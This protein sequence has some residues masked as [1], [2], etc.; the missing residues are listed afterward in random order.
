MAIFACVWYSSIAFQSLIGRLKTED[1][2][3]FK[4]RPRDPFQSL[5][6]RLKTHWHGA[7]NCTGARVSI[8]YR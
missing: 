7:V 4:I 2:V 5:I 6:G 3:G 1:K 8:P